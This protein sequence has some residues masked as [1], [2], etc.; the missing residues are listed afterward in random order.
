MAHGMSDRIREGLSGLP[1]HVHGLYAGTGWVS[2]TTDETGARLRV[3]RVG[4]AEQSATYL[5]ERRF[6][7]PFEYL[8]LFDLALQDAPEAPRVAMIGGGCFSWPKHALVRW[9]GIRLTVVEPEPALVELARSE[10][11][12]DEA[13]R[14]FATHPIDVRTMTGQD[15]LASC[16]VTFDALLVDAFVGSQADGGLFAP[17]HVR[18]M[19]ACLGDKSILAANVVSALSGRRAQAL[20]DVAHA[21][22]DVFD[23]VCALPMNMARPR[24]VD[25]VVVFASRLPLAIPGSLPL[26]R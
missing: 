21:L 20:D 19:R 18:R 14:R 23:H 5:D 16:D 15:F 9:P 24:A 26:E 17:Q 10:F 4:G 2:E 7:L 12:L 22:G 3:L 8:S 25:N 1:H 11:F 6:D 13:E